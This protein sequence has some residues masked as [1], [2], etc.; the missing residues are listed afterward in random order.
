MNG[1]HTFVH[2]AMKTGFTLRILHSDTKHAKQAALAAIE[3]LDLIENRL[4]R[5]IEG[6]DVWRINHMQKGERLFLSD[7]CYECLLLG[8]EAYEHTGGLFDIT[9]GRLIEHQKT[10][11]EG[12]LPGLV[13]TLM[14]DPDKPA[15]HCVEAGREIDLGGIGKGFALDRMKSLMEEWGIQS[16]LL[17]AGASTHLAFGSQRWPITLTGDHSSKV[18]NLKNNALSSSG[19]GIQDCHIVSSFAPKDAYSY[20]RVWLLD[21]TATSADIWSTTAMLIPINE[22]SALATSTTAI[23]AEIGEEIRAL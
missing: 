3:L 12:D 22:L 2:K 1:H 21:R 13:G 7:E 17:S 16:G 23:Y 11:A 6:S 4:S 5:Y 19:I 15:V 10:G 14:V 20:S 8:L 18:I 9:L